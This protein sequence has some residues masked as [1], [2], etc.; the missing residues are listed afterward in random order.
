MFCLFS[1]LDG[2]FCVLVCF[3]LVVVVLGAVKNT[4]V[5]P[6]LGGYKNILETS[7]FATSSLPLSIKDCH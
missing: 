7:C 6:G 1:C 4:D 3:V 2:R 5:Q